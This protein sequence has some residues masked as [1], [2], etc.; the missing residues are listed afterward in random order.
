MQLNFHLKDLNQV[1]CAACGQLFGSK[2]HLDHH[3][4]KKKK[5]RNVRFAQ[6][7]LKVWMNRIMSQAK[8]NQS[9]KPSV[10]KL[11]ASS[12]LQRL[13]FVEVFCWWTVSSWYQQ[14]RRLILSAVSHYIML[15]T[16]QRSKN[17][18]TRR[19]QLRLSH[20]R[21]GAIYKQRSNH[22]SSWWVK[23]VL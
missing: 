19:W 14:K 17:W 8:Q 13:I 10:Y 20:P 12:L 1:S 11:I 3:L 9:K 23:G 15:Q 7:T 5:H 22:M 18:S 16:S 6:K 21:K 4:R 2:E